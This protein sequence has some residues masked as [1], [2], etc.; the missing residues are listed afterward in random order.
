MNI[1]YFLAL[2]IDLE[3]DF[4][5]YHMLPIPT[6]FGSEYRT[7]IPKTAYLLKSD[8]NKIKPLSDICTGTK[9]FQCPSHLLTSV[10]LPCEEDILLK[11]TSSN[12]DYTKVHIA[13]SY[14]E[15]I[16]EINQYLL[17]FPKEKS[18]STQC[19]GETNSRQLKGIFFLKE[20]QCHVTIENQDISNSDKTYGSATVIF[21]E[22]LR[23]HKNQSSNVTI[24]L[25]DYK[26]KNISLSHVKRLIPEKTQEYKEDYKFHLP[27]VWTIILYVSV[28]IVVLIKYRK[29]KRTQKN[30]GTDRHHMKDEGTVETEMKLPGDASF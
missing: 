3:E 26:P 1:I 30:E 8:S 17:I 22:N 10:S 25:N 23:I 21:H 18:I 11:G 7:I 29:F 14:Y 20:D 28:I 27:S 5:L 13:E 12:C 9:V 19:E 15:I 2:P 6:K 16:P 24:N 4:L